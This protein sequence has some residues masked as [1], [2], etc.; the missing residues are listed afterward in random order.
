MILR[1][2]SR[3]EVSNLILLLTY[4]KNK[5]HFFQNNKAKFKFY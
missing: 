2:N 1:L 5:L 4:P 3:A